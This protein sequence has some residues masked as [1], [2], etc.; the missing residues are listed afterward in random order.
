M[1]KI[2][3]IPRQTSRS[4]GQRGS[5][6]AGR[7]SAKAGQSRAKKNSGIGIVIG[8]LGWA[9][10]IGVFAGLVFTVKKQ[11]EQSRHIS[12]NQESRRKEIQA[13]VIVRQ[14]KISERKK[15][16]QQDIN[17]AIK[18]Q[19]GLLSEI[20]GFNAVIKELQ[21]EVSG[22]ERTHGKLAQ[23]VTVIK[24][25]VGVTGEGLQDLQKRLNKLEKRRSDLKEEYRRRFET[26][27]VLFEAKKARPEPEM[28]RQFYGTHRHTVFAPAAGYW[29]GEKL[30]AGKR[31][32][33][34]L[35]L[36]HDVVKRYPGSVYSD[37][38]RSRI[39][40]IEAGTPYKEPEEA[41][42]FHAYHA[43]AVDSSDN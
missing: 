28:L 15:Q 2:K 39:A 40:E 23:S 4:A 36:Y 24:D 21:G 26:M 12:D 35:R 41:V 8:L 17:G 31:S 1:V 43:F 14:T 30:Y 38:C 29:T 5:G 25:D 22:L 32:K 3:N 20:Q 33:D 42:G 6:G 11:Q 7:Q 13:S 37:N 18:G 34:A 16:L 10:A 9:A 27:R 19:S